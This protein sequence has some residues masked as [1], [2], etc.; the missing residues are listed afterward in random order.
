MV[1]TDYYLLKWN[2]FKIVELCIEISK[3]T[4]K[5]YQLWLKTAR[6]PPDAH[7][8]LSVSENSGKENRGRKL[9]KEENK[10]LK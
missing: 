3:K 2:L 5:A 10:I 4:A 6:H 7:L 8:N 9:E 1:Q